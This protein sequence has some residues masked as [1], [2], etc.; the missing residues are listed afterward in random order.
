MRNIE[1][2]VFFGHS[3]TFSIAQTI[4]SNDRAIDESINMRKETVVD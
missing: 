4:L 2:K 3:T 1:V